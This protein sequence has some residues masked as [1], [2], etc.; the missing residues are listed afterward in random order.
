[1]GNP[2]EIS[3]VE[4]ARLVRRI[5]ASDSEIRLVPYDEAYQPGF[6]DMSRRVPD[7]GKISRLVGFKPKIK[8]HDIVVR[9][10]ESKRQELQ[11]LVELPVTAALQQSLRLG[12]AE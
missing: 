3:I 8:L 6:E 11:E 9:V 7:I 1:M 4:L 5:C 2:E 12:V 10:I